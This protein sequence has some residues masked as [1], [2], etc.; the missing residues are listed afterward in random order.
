MRPAVREVRRTPARRP[1]YSLSSGS[2]EPIGD[3]QRLAPSPHDDT[4]PTTSA[5]Q[6]NSSG[7][8]DARASQNELIVSGEKIVQSEST[9]PDKKIPERTEFVN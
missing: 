5:P 3:A 7:G 9:E 2:N 1:V 4:K 6:P 8:S